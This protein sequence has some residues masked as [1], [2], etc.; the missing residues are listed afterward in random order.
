MKAQITIEMNNAAF[1]CH[2]SELPRILNQVAS[3]LGGDYYKI[4]DSV[5]LYDSYDKKVGYLD[6]L[7]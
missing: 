7:P 5:P 2:P 4:G 1:E 3:Q 6:F